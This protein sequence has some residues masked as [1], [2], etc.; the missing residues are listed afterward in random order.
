[1]N[2]R[3]RH[4]ETLCFGAPDR[5]PLEPGH[6]RKSTRAR[7]VRDGMSDDARNPVDKA[8]E[9]AGVTARTAHSNHGF[10]VDERMRPTFEEAIL[11]R[12][13]ST[14]VVRDWKGNICEISDE[15]SPEYLREGIDFVTR[16]WIRCPVENHHDWQEM[17]QRYD[18][19]DPGRLPEHARSL[20]AALAD[21]DYFIELHFSGPFWQLREWL[22]FER[23]CELFIDDP[24]W[25]QDMVDFWSTFVATLIERTLRVFIP[26]SIHISEDMAYKAHPMISPAM[27]RQFLLP[28]WRRWGDLVR[29]SS[30]PIYSMDSDG[31]IADLI[32]I[33]IDA[34]FN[35]CDPVEVA[36]HNDINDF[37][38]RFGRNMAYRGGVDK[39]AIAAGGSAI[40]AELQRLRPVIRDGGF[41]PGCD[42]GVPADVSWQDYV[43]YAKLLASETGWL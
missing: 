14:L 38:K 35:V 31:Y 15:F 6:G 4:I 17:Q 24:A 11:E 16:R 20:G 40:V 10:I 37:R 21:R 8:M 19:A 34:G 41:I 33:W 5:I 30:C 23:L 39:R 1:M 13:K 12:R 9:A 18:A 28:A 22:G 32:P 29:A 42:H 43:R 36:A 26:D 3:Q 7:W 25:I 2:D 27:T